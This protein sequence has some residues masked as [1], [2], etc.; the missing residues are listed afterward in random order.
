MDDFLS[1]IR[2]IGKSLTCD[3][4][5]KDDK[6]ANGPYLRILESDNDEHLP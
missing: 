1:E 3:V 4:S 2:F 5:N 6:N